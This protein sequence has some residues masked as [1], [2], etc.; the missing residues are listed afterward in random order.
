MNNMLLT[1]IEQN[2]PSLPDTVVKLRD[3]INEKGSKIELKGV[4]DII[5][6]DPLTT[7]NLLR[8]ANSAY[9]GF[10]S[11]ISTINQVIALL[12]IDNVKNIVMAD[13]LRSLIR[14]NLSPYGLDT[15]LFLGNCSKEVDFISNWLNEEDRKLA[16]TLVP[17]AMLLRLGMILFSSVL[18]KAKR[19]KEFR[20]AL[21][22]NDFKNIALVEQE[23][24]G[25]DHI[26]FLA[27]CFDHWKFDELLIQTIV[28]VINPHSAPLSIK[29]NAYALAI[30]NRLFEP[31][32]GGN[33]YNTNEAIAL[34]KE[35]AQQG[36]VFKEENLIKHMPSMLKN[37][38]NR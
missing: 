35:A 18:I 11:E 21:K 38:S 25:V 14:V 23:F 10:S 19:D 30:A 12:G 8:T 6:R 22:Q 9:Y 3:Y 24:F 37:T 28:Y 20:E 26:S 2:L 16:Q 27:Y 32:E 34:T 36:I 4:V 1:L 5:S 13:S 31:Y 7:A 29:K 17:C 33:D 15:D